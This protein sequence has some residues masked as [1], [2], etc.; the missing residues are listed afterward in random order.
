MPRYFAQG[1][2]ALDAFLKSREARSTLFSSSKRTGATTRY[3]RLSAR[4]KEL[5]P[6]VLQTK[7]IGSHPFL[8]IFFI[9]K[10]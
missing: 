4:R 7:P 10:K 2:K 3:V 1:R 6:S 9:I 8:G 5:T